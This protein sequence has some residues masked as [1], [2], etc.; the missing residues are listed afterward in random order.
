MTF[1][2][3][4]RIATGRT[5]SANFGWRSEQHCARPRR[6]PASPGLLDVPRQ[7]LG[8]ARV[9]EVRRPMWMAAMQLQ[10]SA[11]SEEAKQ[12]QE[13]IAELKRRKA[14]KVA[15]V[16]VFVPTVEEI[17]EI[18]SR[19]ESLEQDAGRWKMF[20]KMY[21]PLEATLKAIDAAIAAAREG[22][23]TTVEW[24]PSRQRRP[25]RSELGGML[26]VSTRGPMT[27][28]TPKQSISTA[29]GTGEL[30]P[31]GEIYEQRRRAGVSWSAN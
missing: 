3:G 13:L 1:G 12:A 30:K 5:C 6:E 14:G 23:C 22:G 7:R 17:I 16:G 18:L 4:V 24:T 10:E 31:Q 25:G 2:D 9:G 15:L 28:H 11:V 26:S 20:I 27:C 19:F 8:V 29:T 21:N